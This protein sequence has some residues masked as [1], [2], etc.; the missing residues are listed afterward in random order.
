MERVNEWRNILIRI[1]NL[2]GFHSSQ[3]Y[4][5]EYECVEEIFKDILRKLEHLIPS[6][7]KS[8]KIND[9]NLV[10]I[11]LATIINNHV[12]CNITFLVFTELQIVK[13]CGGFPLVLKLVGRS[14][15]GQPPVIWQDRVMD[16]SKGNFFDAELLDKLEQL[17]DVLGTEDIIKECFLDLCLFPEDQRIP[18][19][20]LIDM[21]VE[22]H[23]LDEDGV[24]AMTYII[25]LN[26][27]NLADT[28]VTRKLAGNMDNYYNY[29]F[30]TQHDLLREVAIK[31]NNNGP[32]D[33]RKRLIVELSEN[34]VPEWW[35]KKTSQ[36]SSARRLLLDCLPLRWTSGTEEM[37]QQSSSR[38]LLLDCLPIWT[39]DKPQKNIAR[40]LSISI[41]LFFFNS[42]FSNHS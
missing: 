17:V 5:D 2:A 27:W 23:K 9:F 41:G 24:K 7:F 13:G 6:F 28:V 18:A 31:K 40:R 29:H 38:R 12:H 35:T 34:S 39:I 1:A 36:Q 19:A 4:R 3:N 10:F 33:G 16:L 37:P 8:N 25:K 11:S 14:L 26:S 15:S 21:W 22:L 42:L 32:V 30:I 20:A